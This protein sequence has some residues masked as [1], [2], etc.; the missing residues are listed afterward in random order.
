M[1]PVRFQVLRL[2][3]PPLP[4]RINNPRENEEE[5]STPAQRIPAH[6]PAVVTLVEIKVRSS[7]HLN[8]QRSVAGGQHAQEEA[9]AEEKYAIML[10]D[11]SV[12]EEDPLRCQYP[13]RRK[14]ALDPCGPGILLPIRERLWGDV[15]QHEPG[16]QRGEQ[17][18]KE[19]HLEGHPDAECIAH[20]AAE[21]VGDGLAQHNTALQLPEDCRPLHRLDQLAGDSV[22]HEDVPCGTAQDSDELRALDDSYAGI[23]TGQDAGNLCCDADGR[24]D[25]LY[26][27]GKAGAP[28]LHRP[29]G[30]EE[31]QDAA[32]GGAHAQK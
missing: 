1:N 5:E 21:E 23:T 30:Q 16:V 8:Q 4:T 26:Y 32:E 27:E 24:N 28:F 14:E 29:A 9:T 20:H 22:D 15:R 7:V 18:Q 6:Q 19:R 11:V 17:E 13:E 12:Q 25:G 10:P 3:H 2:H 31:V